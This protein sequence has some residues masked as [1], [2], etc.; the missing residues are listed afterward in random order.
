VSERARHRFLPSS[1]RS[2][3]EPSSH[4]LAGQRAP[5][6]IWLPQRA[7]PVTLTLAGGA[8]FPGRVLERAADMLLVAVIVP[9]PALSARQLAKLVLEYANPGG[10]VRLNGD[11]TMESEPDGATVRI[12]HPQLLEVIQ[13]R[14]HVRVEADLPI[15]VKVAAEAE[16][17]HAR[18]VDLSAGGVLLG[19]PDIVQLGDK[20]TFELVL[21][22]GTAPVTGLGEVARLD[23]ERRAGIQFTKLDPYEQWRLIRFTVEVQEGEGFRQVAEQ[24]RA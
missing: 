7:E 19:V 12:E 21:E 3:E 24:G 17:I 9:M 2:E 4:E 23:G 13:E 15:V 6:P 22:P 14:A 1:H 18:T 5:R 20:L 16:A 11:T 10:R 8:T